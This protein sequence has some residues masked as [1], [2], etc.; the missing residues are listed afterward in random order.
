MRM[1]LNRVVFR[2]L[3][4]LVFALSLTA[5]PFVSAQS[6]PRTGIQRVIDEAFNQGQLDVIDEVFAENYVSHPDD[7]DRDAFKANILAQRDAMPDLHASADLITVEGE[8][9]A[10]RFTQD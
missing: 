7:G 1:I 5:A 2:S 3:L 4:V 8:W 10:F 6:D 9:A